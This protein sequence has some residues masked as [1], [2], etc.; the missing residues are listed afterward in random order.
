M[1][2]FTT[3]TLPAGWR[4]VEV[5]SMITNRRSIQISQK[6]LL[7]S[8]V[9]RNRNEDQE[10]YD[11]FVAHA[12]NVRCPSGQMANAVI[13]TRISTSTAQ[14]SEGTMLIVTYYGTAVRIE[15]QNV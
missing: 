2:V 4:V 14:F 13:G 3:E 12:Q 5:G 8:I 10:A 6:G 1:D 7:Q 9:D 15:P 11:G